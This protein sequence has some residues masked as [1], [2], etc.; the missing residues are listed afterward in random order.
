[1]RTGWAPLLPRLRGQFAEFLRGVSPATL[2]GLARSP[3][4]SVCGTGTRGQDGRFFLGRLSGSDGLSVNPSHPTAPSPGR[5]SVPGW[6]GN[7]N[8]TSPSATPFG[9]TLGSRLTLLRWALS[10]KPWASGREDSHLPRVT[11][12]GILTSRRSTRP[13]GRASQHRERPPTIRFLLG[14]S[15][16]LASAPSLSPVGFSAPTR[17]AGELLRTL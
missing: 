1:M 15:G 10:R 3:P 14:R 11:S 8:P 12:A 7:I 16:P 9:L 2:P 17:S 13:F 4:V 6:R 5:L